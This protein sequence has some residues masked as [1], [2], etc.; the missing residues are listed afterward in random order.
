MSNK[1]DERL[2]AAI[3]TTRSAFLAALTAAI[4]AGLEVDIELERDDDDAPSIPIEVRRRIRV[5]PPS[6][7]LTGRAKGGHA[8]AA[9]LSPAE[10]RAIAV[11]AANARWGTKR[12]AG[13][14][15]P[16]TPD[17]SDAMAKPSKIGKRVMT[18]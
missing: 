8:R 18:P 4:R 10:R 2:L 15:P 13:L 9:S 12:L 17:A 11:T 3:L 6:A 14:T 1:S 5:A 16:A 7:A